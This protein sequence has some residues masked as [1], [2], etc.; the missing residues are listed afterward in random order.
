MA[1]LPAFQFYPG[2]WRKDMGVQSLNFHDRGVWWEMLCLMHESEQRGKL[3][4]NGVAIGDE[5]LSRLLGLDKQILTTTLTT[6]LT[7]GVAS[8]DEVSGA[9]LCRR[10]VRDEYIRKVRSEAG[11]KGGNPALLNQNSTIGDKQITTPSSSTT[12]STS[13][14]VKKPKE[15]PVRFTLPFWVPVD[16]WTGFEEMRKKTRHPLTDRARRLVIAELNDLRVAGHDPLAVLNQSIARDYR[17]VF[18]VKDSGGHQN[19]KG[20]YEKP[21]TADRQAVELQRSVRDYAATPRA[22]Q[23]GGGALGDGGGPGDP[24]PDPRSV[25]ADS[26]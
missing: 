20:T 9:I 2:D 7:S 1:K 19:G 14:S 5:S 25:G 6:L 26:W 17:G 21:T 23:D 3:L 22:D 8:R 13:P 16:A 11:S 4:L 18:P 24:L 10:M 15:E 12:V